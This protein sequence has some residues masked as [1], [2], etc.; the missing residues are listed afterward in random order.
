MNG[1]I[2]SN[3]ERKYH[4]RCGGITKDDKKAKVMQSNNWECYICRS[5]DNECLCCTDKEKE[6]RNLKTNNVKLEK[7]LDNMTHE[8]KLCQEKCINLE[9]RLHKEKKRRRRVERDLEELQQSSSHESSDDNT[10]SEWVDSRKKKPR[11]YGN[12]EKSKSRSDER[13]RQNGGNHS[14]TNV[15]RSDRPSS[16]RQPLAKS[17]QSP[18]DHDSENQELESESQTDGESRNATTDPGLQMAY[19]FLRKYGNDGDQEDSE[20]PSGLLCW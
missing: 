18:D 17:R 11:K 2:C 9:E 8:L 7:K 15:T 10:E 14:R 12:G 20:S 1:I 3:C 16:K 13:V 19:E 4:W 5:S 6:V